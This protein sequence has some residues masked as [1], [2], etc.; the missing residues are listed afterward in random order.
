[1]GRHLSPKH[2]LLTPN[3]RRD[4]LAHI[5]VVQLI[6]QG[7]PELN[8]VSDSK[9]SQLFEIVLP[10]AELSAASGQPLLTVH[11]SQGIL[12]GAQQPVGV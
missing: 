3:Q 11:F 12:S 2:S 1:M 8:K 5:T 7:H 4:T 9:K 10:E 6:D